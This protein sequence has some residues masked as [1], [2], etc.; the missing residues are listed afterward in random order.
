MKRF[1]NINNSFKSATPEIKGYKEGGEQLIQLL[2][3]HILIENSLNKE[4]AEYILDNN[5]WKKISVYEF[6]KGF[7]E[8]EKNSNDKCIVYLSSN[9]HSICDHTKL[10][11]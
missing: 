8:I 5:N 10:F 4:Q 11:G 2:F 7:S 6:K 9:K 1:F 3:G